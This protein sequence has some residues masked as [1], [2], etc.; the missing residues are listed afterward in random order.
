MPL[1]DV[2]TSAARLSSS[3]SS[4]DNDRNRFSVGGEMVNAPSSKLSDASSFAA[5]NVSFEANTSESAASSRDAP[6]G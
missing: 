4:S 6:K 1:L 3:G 2:S 5:P